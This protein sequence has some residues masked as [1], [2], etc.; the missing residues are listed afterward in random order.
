MGKDEGKRLKKSLVI[1]VGSLILVVIGFA[2]YFML[3]SSH[4]F[5]SSHTVHV[6]EMGSNNFVGYSNGIYTRIYMAILVVFTQ[7][8]KTIATCNVGENGRFA[9]TE[10]P[11]QNVTLS[12]GPYVVGVYNADSGVF[13]QRIEIY[14]A[15]ETNLSLGP[16]S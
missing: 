14:V 12:D 3:T 8:N 13:I 7:D 5:V 1:V 6:K 16:Y 10:L 11:T 4:M 9:E 15:N 2:S